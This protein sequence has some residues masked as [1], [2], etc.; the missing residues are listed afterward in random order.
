MLKKG[1]RGDTVRRLQEDLMLLGCKLPRWG[2]DGSLGDETLQ[3][4]HSLLVAKNGPPAIDGDMSSISDSELAYIEDMVT[5]L[6]TSNSPGG[7]LD[8][9]NKH[10]L[11]RAELVKV[12]SYQAITSIVLHQTACQLGERPDRW[13]SVP[14][15]IGITRSGKILWLNDFT[16]NLPHANGFNGRS[17]GIEIDGAFAGIEGDMKTFWRPAGSNALPQE[18]SVEQLGAARV[19]VRWICEEVARHG[20][21]ILNILAHRQSSKDRVS[22]PGSRIWQNVGVWALHLKTATPREEGAHRDRLAM[23]PE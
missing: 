11:P 3:A 6:A 7:L 16:F 14:I 23:L 19:A 4:A 12:R 20:G 5:H 17:I 15:H 2:A 22:D 8:E 18:A 13:Y 9:R 21:K 10:S 1:D